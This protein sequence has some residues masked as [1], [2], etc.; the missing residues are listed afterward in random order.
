MKVNCN[1]DVKKL[2]NLPEMSEIRN[3]EMV[4]WCV[5]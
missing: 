4:Y 3:W 5:M 2:F 1:A